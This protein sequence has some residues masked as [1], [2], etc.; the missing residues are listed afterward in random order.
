MDNKGTGRI[1]KNKFLESLTRTHI[2]VPLTIFYGAAAVLIGYSLYYGTIAPLSNLWMFV[3]GFLFFTLVEYLVHR[4]A[5]HIDTDT[6]GKAKF[7]YTFHGVHHDYPRDKSRLA[8]PPLMSVILALAFFFF[9]KLILGFYGLPFAGGF[10]A[11]YATY[12]CVHYSVHA[13]RPPK[14]FL[15]ILWVH[16]AIHHYQDPDR[17]FGVSSPLWD[18]I[19][20]TMP[21][22]TNAMQKQE[23]AV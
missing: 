7:Q 8:M 5:F 13:F 19:F 2:A 14:N 6:P 16:H 17:A 9:Y 15:K 21:K 4:Y 23:T 3:G 1:F 18:V 20:G 11:G 10:M 12:L 22:K